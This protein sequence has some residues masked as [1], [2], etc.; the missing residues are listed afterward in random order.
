MSLE[1]GVDS[2]VTL[3]EAGAYFAARPDAEIWAVYE[4][5]S[6]EAFLR[7]AY[8]RITASCL[9]DFP[10]PYTPENAPPVVKKAQCEWAIGLS[11][12]EEVTE[13]SDTL[14]SQLTAGPVTMKFDNQDSSGNQGLNDF[15][16]ALLRNGGCSCDFD[17]S[18]ASEGVTNGTVIF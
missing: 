6:K 4:E 16:K 10:E 13:L 12:A 3:E 18:A 8:D 9:C 5:Q 7:A 1:P 2:F 17:E 14:L 15:V 11:K